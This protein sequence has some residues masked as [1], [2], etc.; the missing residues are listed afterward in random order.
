MSAEQNKAMLRRVFE[1]GMNA[2]RLDVYDEI[3]TPGFVSHDFP[4]SSTGPE[5]FKQIVTMFVTAFPDLNITIEEVIAEG[6]M[7]ASRGIARG[8]HQGEF[9]GVPATGNS[10]SMGFIDMWRVSEGKFIEN[11]ARLDMLSMMQQLGAIPA[12]EGAVV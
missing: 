2:Q 5:G 7:V 6:D 3:I 9:M 10:V 8:T 11:W 12:P 4:G 1:E